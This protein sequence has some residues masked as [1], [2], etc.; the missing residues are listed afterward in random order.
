M[1]LNLLR[2][3]LSHPAFH[4]SYRRCFE[5]LLDVEAAALINATDPTTVMV[6]LGRLKLLEQLLTWPDRLAALNQE[7]Y[8][9]RAKRDRVLTDEPDS[10]S[11]HLGSPLF[12]SRF[13]ERNADRLVAT[14][15]RT[16]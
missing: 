14:R 10:A 15:E 5:P 6:A 16:D 12:R 8:D 1:E 4:S 7:W 3:L 9:D 2:E 13:D 11:F